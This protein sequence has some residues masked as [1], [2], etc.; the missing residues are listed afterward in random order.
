MFCL[1]SQL[2][3]L[4]ILQN[5]ARTLERLL[6]KATPELFFFKEYLKSKTETEIFNGK[7]VKL[8]FIE[9]LYFLGIVLGSGLA[10]SSCKRPTSTHFQFCRTESHA[11]IIGFCY[12]STSSHRRFLNEL[13]CLCANKALC[14]KAGG[15]TDLACR[16]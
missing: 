16:L 4:A 11:T 1:V 2:K 5:W 8:T 7:K 9:C 10:K 15:R 13:V 6:E 3:A 12:R 14:T